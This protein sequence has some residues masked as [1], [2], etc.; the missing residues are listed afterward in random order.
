MPAKKIRVLI[1]DD[2]MVFRE[3]LRREISSD[4]GLE[5][6]ALAANAYEARDAIEEHV[7]DVMALDVEMPRMNGIEFLKRLM[8][9]F[10]MPV[11]VVSAVSDNVF[12]ALRAGAVDF[13]SKPDAQNREVLSAFSAEL[14]VKLKV[15]SMAKVG[16]HKPTESLRS[17]SREADARASGRARNLIAI[18]ASTGGTEAIADVLGGLTNRCVPIVIVQHMPP[19]FTT[20]YAKRLNQQ[21][22]MEVREAEDGDV[23]REGLV[24]LAPGDRHMSL[25]RRAGG[26]AVKLR[27]GERVSG[28]CPSVDVL[29]ESV[30]SV[31]GAD[32][33][34]VILTGMGRDGAGGLLK[35]KSAG[36]WTIGQDEASC[37]VYGM[38]MVAW[39]IGA[40]CRQV[41]LNRVSE[42]IS[43][44]VGH[45]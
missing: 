8:P 44:A 41:P 30:A 9:Q 16:E 15:A 40:V 36:A 5:V 25:V 39:N 6:V 1:V 24:L 22:A 20:M 38:P 21:C 11:V 23:L 2:S 33:V 3:F 32:A 4:P 42:Q 45:A 34:G 28:H 18:G 26:Y 10:P 17:A 14:I 7:P 31:A 27:A 37:V 12:E 13:V 35:M 19:V 29:F 43:Q